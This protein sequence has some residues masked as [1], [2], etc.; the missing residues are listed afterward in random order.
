MKQESKLTKIRRKKGFTVERVAQVL[1]VSKK[2]VVQWEEKPKTCPPSRLE[3]LS[4][5]FHVE[6]GELVC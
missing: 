1:N 5:L 6:E 3:E 2:K 4:W